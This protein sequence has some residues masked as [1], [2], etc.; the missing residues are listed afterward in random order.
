MADQLNIIK[1]LIKQGAEV[2]VKDKIH[3]TPLHWA[4]HRGHHDIVKVLLNKNASC[5]IMDAEGVSPLHLAIKQ[6]ST[7]CL[8]IMLDHFQ[9]TKCDLST[10]IDGK[11][12]TPVHWAA[13]S[14]FS[15]HLAIIVKHKLKFDVNRN[16]DEGRTPLMWAALS[17]LESSLAC[18]KIL[19]DREPGTIRN[20]DKCGF[21]ALHYA[22][23][24]NNVPVVELLLKA[25]YC[26]VNVLDNCYRTP[27]H[28]ACK[29][30]LIDVVN[31]LLKHGATLQTD[32]AGATP[33][34]YAAQGDHV[35]LLERL[36]S[37]SN[38]KKDLLDCDGKSS[39][40]YAAS[41]G[42]NA[43]IEFMMRKFQGSTFA[44]LLFICKK[45]ALN[46]LKQKSLMLILGNLYV[47]EQ[48]CL[49]ILVVVTNCIIE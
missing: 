38:L 41:S 45:V 47:V 5:T 26:N 25:K 14:G 49:L 29:L 31:L 42:A 40:M 44:F 43:V 19:I 20:Q 23:S 6:P 10:L 48:H 34:H 9:Q 12:R 30:N 35:K 2:D 11:G 22:V 15:D 21:S 7:K 33:L 16:D 39:L 4:A 17:N 3:R 27:L 36:I 24:F 46:L 8:E 37:S 18:C 1:W 28:W 32:G 13:A